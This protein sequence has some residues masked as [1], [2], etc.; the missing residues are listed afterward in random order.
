VEN[1]PVPL[2]VSPR[3]GL[4]N[5][6]AWVPTDDKIAF[7]DRLSAAG[8]PAIEVTAFVNPA[9]VPQMADA[10]AVL[11]GITRRP[12]TRYSALVPNL[13]GLDRAARCD[14]YE[15]AIF[16]AAS[17]TFS[18]RNIQQS[19]D[20]S[21]D[22]YALV[23]RR[24]G[25]ADMRVR[26]YLSTAFGC[27]YEGEVPV[28]RVVTLTRRLLDIGVAEVAIS[29][30]IGMAHPA[31]V[32]TVIQALTAAA[33]PIDRVALHF[34]DTRGMAIANVLVGLDAGIRVFDASSGGLGGCPYAPGA[35]GNVAMEELIYLLEGLGYATG[36]DLMRLCDAAPPLEPI[37]GHPLP[38]RVLRAVL[39][40]KRTTSPDNA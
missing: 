4:Q 3:D 32:R 28:D 25:E 37:I 7:V 27:P 19:I 5:E 10:E 9:R 1:R 14:L 12:G 40:A 38:S 17:E 18:Q 11:A 30:T 35:T 22:Q 21:L 24:A 39:A 16:A 29:D 20:A 8:L 6:P 33:V 34:H 15:I 13:R 2:D 36:V 26:G 31:Q 23:V